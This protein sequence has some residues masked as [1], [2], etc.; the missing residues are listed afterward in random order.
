M[1]GTVKPYSDRNM[2][3]DCTLAQRAVQPTRFH[4]PRLLTRDH[5]FNLCCDLIADLLLN[6]EG[7]V[8]WKR[9]RIVLQQRRMLQRRVSQ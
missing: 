1:M 5:V 3:A 4:R 6:S 7:L 8:T 2:R 9:N